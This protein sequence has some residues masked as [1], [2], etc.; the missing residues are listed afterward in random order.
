MRAMLAHERT[1]SSHVGDEVVEV[2]LLGELGEKSG[3]VALNL[4]TSGLDDGG[5]IVGRHL[6]AIVLADEGSVDASEFTEDARAIRVRRESR[7]SRVEFVARDA[8]RPM[9]SH[10]TW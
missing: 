5:N 2:L 10:K 4:D 6:N 7:P 8:R 9:K 1:S 3:P